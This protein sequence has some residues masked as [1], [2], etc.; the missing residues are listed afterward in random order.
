[1]KMLQDGMNFDFFFHSWLNHDSSIF[2]AIISLF[3]K[4]KVKFNILKNKI[5]NNEKFIWTK[6][7]NQEAKKSYLYSGD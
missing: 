7:V 2:K 3:G 1:M 5:H 4:W 6:T